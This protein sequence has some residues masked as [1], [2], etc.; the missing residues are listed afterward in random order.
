MI[1]G[2]YIRNTWIWRGIKGRA[3]ENGKLA[4]IRPKLASMFLK[5]SFF[6]IIRFPFFK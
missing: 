2:K 1:E 5:K 3:A 4:G 6:Y